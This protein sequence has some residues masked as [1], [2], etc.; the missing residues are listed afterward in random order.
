MLLSTLL[1]VTALA[2]PESASNT[3]KESTTPAPVESRPFEISWS[4]PKSCPPREQAI[5]AIDTLLGDLEP[6]E[7]RVRAGVTIKQRRARF[8]LELMLTTQSGTGKR[9]LSGETCNE[10]VDAAALIVAI[11]INPK[12]LER[13]AAE[14]S[15]ESQGTADGTPEEAVTQIEPEPAEEPP[16]TP[17]PERKPRPRVAVH[18]AGGLGAFVLPGPTAALQLGVG[19]TGS[20]WRVDAIGSYWTR[21][22]QVVSEMVSG[23]FQLGYAGVRG[24]GVP[25]AGP[26]E[27][28]ICGGL[29]VGAMRGEGL[30]EGLRVAR[31]QNAIWLAARAGPSVLWRTTRWLGLMLQADAVFPLLRPVFD[32]QPSGTEVFRAGPAGLKLLLGVEFRLG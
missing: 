19:V 21:Q 4:A 1:L 3:T 13:A 7:T 12:V 16:P 30:G 18:A 27:F 2:P 8:E 10:V 20:H 24:C 32:T 15:S 28:P 29:D 6:R 14:T 11:A 26:V 25:V 9:S 22:T 17:T 5:K 23:H 31:A